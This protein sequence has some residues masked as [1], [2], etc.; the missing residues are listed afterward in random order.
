[1]VFVSNNPFGPAR[2]ATFFRARNSELGR[3]EVPNYLG[4]VLAVVVVVVMV[5]A[6]VMVVVVVVMLRLTVA[7]LAVV[8]GRVVPRGA[9]SD[10]V[11]KAPR[12]GG[13]S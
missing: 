3:F 11:G 1:M 10:S 13:A 4:V 7:Q 12:P 9:V 5:V 8:G 2:P 6:V